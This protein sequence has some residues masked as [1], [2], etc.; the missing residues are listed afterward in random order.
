MN[1]ANLPT[2]IFLVVTALAIGY[3]FVEAVSGDDDEGGRP[4]KK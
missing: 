1:M 2:I 3:G 4:F